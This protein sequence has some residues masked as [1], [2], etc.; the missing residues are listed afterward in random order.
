MNHL[1]ALRF[2]VPQ[3]GE[4]GRALLIPQPMRG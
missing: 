3:T 1:K 4:G 2:A